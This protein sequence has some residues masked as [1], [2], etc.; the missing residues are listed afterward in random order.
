MTLI[1][2]LS[3]IHGAEWIQ[4]VCKQLRQKRKSASESWPFGELFQS[5]CQKMWEQNICVHEKG[6]LFLV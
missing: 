4:K 6:E 3:A 2:G 5:R 1:K